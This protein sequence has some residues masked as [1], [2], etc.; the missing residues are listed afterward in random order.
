[1][2][3]IM[4]SLTGQ[5]RQ[6]AMIDLKTR[7]KRILRDGAASPRYA[8][9]GHLLFQRD[10]SFFAAPFDLK[11]LQIRGSEVPVIEDVSS[12]PWLTPSLAL[13][14]RGTLVYLPADDRD[15]KGAP[16]VWV[17]RKGT[18]TPAAPPGRYDSVR[19]SPDGMKAATVIQGQIWVYDLQRGTNSRITFDGTARSPLWSPDGKRIVYYSETGRQRGV[20]S[21]L[22][23]G[24]GKPEFI[25]AFE[26]SGAFNWS[27]DGKALLM[28][29]WGERTD[30]W[31]VPVRQGQSPAGKPTLLLESPFNKFEPTVSPDGKWLAYRGLDSGRHQV[32]VQPYP[33]LA[34]KWQISTDGGSFPKWSHDGKELFYRA[35]NGTLMAVDVRSQPQFEAGKPV[36]LFRITA[37]YEVAP[38]GRFL[39]IKI[40]PATEGAQ[41]IH[42]EVITDWFEELKRRVP[43]Q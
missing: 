12:S 4:G 41:P 31:T 24:S 19:L 30:L 21:T 13:S 42:V 9:S 34:G 6:A 23:D 38:D 35:A 7:E 8:A 5:H 25:A 20:Y 14:P 22:A 32:Y 1:V 43:V 17:D 15:Q 36:P 3:V 18:E 33:S 11:S 2:T 39:V 10:G 16:L 28:A 29:N 27:P 40:P 37:G 26:S